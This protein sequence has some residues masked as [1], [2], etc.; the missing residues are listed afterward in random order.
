VEEPGTR[1]IEGT[2]ELWR[3]RSSRVLSKDDAREIAEN[4]A[5]FFQ[6]LMEWEATEQ[7][8]TSEVTRT[9]TDTGCHSAVR[10]PE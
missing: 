5:G 6:I 10:C 3:K 7:P 8:T 2:L 1:F 4:V 9:K